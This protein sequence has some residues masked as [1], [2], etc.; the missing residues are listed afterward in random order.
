MFTMWATAKPGVGA[1]ELETALFAEVDQLAAEGPT[2]VELE[3]VAQ[4]A[5]RRGRV[6]PGAHRA[7]APIG[8]RCMPAYSI[9]RSASTPR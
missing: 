4:P 2:A 8:C 6:Q 1:D 3:R 9:S 5:C 7:S